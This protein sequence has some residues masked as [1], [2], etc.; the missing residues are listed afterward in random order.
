VDQ[1]P[2][3]HQQLERKAHDVTDLQ[4]CFRLDLPYERPPEALWANNRPH[5]R[6]RAADTRQVRN[7]VLVRAKQAG[8]HRLPRPVAFLDL[9]LVWA[10]GDNRR[11]DEDNLFPLLKACADALAR[12]PR[13]D[14]IGLEIVPDDTKRY[15]KK[16]PV[17][18]GPPAKGMWLDIILTYQEDAA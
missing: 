9:T 4:T 1:R 18:L 11:R 12:G 6:Q 10:A 2:T 3:A 7:D 5:Y 14:W 13:R 15:M 8:L 16:T 17:L